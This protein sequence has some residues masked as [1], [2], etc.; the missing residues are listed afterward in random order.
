M[1]F[2]LNL[3]ND[4]EIGHILIISSFNVLQIGLKLIH[5]PFFKKLVHLLASPM[6]KEIFFKSVLAN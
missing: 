2:T 4:L 5:P 3:L 6:L 1:F